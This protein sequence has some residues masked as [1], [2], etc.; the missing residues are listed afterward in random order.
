MN[1]RKALSIM[2]VTAMLT[3]GCV[4]PALGED[5]VP[6]VSSQEPETEKSGGN[7]DKGEGSPEGGQSGA[8]SG[9]V[10]APASGGSEIEL[11]GDDDDDGG[12]QGGDA[13]ETTGG[14]TGETGGETGETGGNTGE[15]GGE[16]AETGGETGGDT[17]ETGGETGETG[18][19][20]VDSADPGVIE[21]PELQSARVHIS[22]GNDVAVGEQT[23][24][25]FE[26]EHAVEVRFRL[27]APDGSTAASGSGGNGEGVYSF[28]PEMG[29]SYTMTIV[30][31]GEDGGEVTASASLN[32]VALPEL[33]LKVKAADPCCHG[34]DPIA[35]SIAVSEGIVVE[36]CSIN[37][38]QSGE[39]I[40]HSS[41]FAEK[42]TFAPVVKKD[43]TKVT[44]TVTIVDSYGREAETSVTIPC[45]VHDEESRS[46][47]EATLRGAQLTGVWPLDVLAIARTQVGYQESQIDFGPKDDGGIS[48][49][50][51]YGHWAGLRYEEWC[52]MFA[53]FCLHYAGVTE[54]HFPYASNGNRWIRKL[55]E[56]GLYAL[57]GSYEPKVGD[58]VFFDWEADGDC[59]HVGIVE[60]VTADASGH[61]TGLTTIEGN[62]KGGC[63]TAGEYYDADNWQ[64][65]GY[66]LVNLAYERTL[67]GQARTLSV[68]AGGVTVT[69]DAGPEAGLPA[70]VELIA[71]ESKSRAKAL[72]GAL[73]S[74]DALTCARFVSLSLTDA[75]GRPVQPLA[76][77]RVTIDI[78]QPLDG[79]GS[80]RPGIAKLSGDSAEVSRD[81]TLTRGQDGASFTF[82]RADVNGVFAAFTTGILKCRKGSLSAKTADA[83]VTMSYPASAG[84]PDNAKLSL[85]EVEASAEL[86]MTLAA[87]A[88]VPEGA[89]VRFFRLGLALN[90]ISYDIDDTAAVVL[91]CRQSDGN[92]RVVCLE[93]GKTPRAQLTA[94][95]KGRSAVAFNAAT[96]GTYAI[97]YS[98]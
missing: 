15:T 79:D 9:N 3:C 46:M 51:R 64:I 14:D 42:V 82:E 75:Q 32:A 34:G 56:K 66:G 72:A 18:G 95:N 8:E 85:A 92:A 23:S 62:S 4:A 35:F 77:V 69:V 44:L 89:Q 67:M 97:I 86:L 54:E 55:T 38:Y 39:E 41:E 43:V 37:A 65:V 53:C 73:G 58:L 21:A 74:A 49:Y 68:Q 59:D 25:R 2:I 13:G 98:E 91:T 70:E 57:R 87:A 31:I 20:V 60:T 84:V 1:I 12:G 47:W 26:V 33:A 29:G 94:L 36:A 63:V 45:A 17:G 61:V 10:E 16:T 90:G 40:F 81:V 6:A 93:N 19:E 5:E 78:D 7:D 71:A 80:L 83:E 50:T 27:V 48:A 96:L 88:Q 28:T 52:D 24:F 11:S 30:A 22:A 76:P